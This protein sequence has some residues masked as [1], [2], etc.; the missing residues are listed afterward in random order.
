MEQKVLN[1][2]FKNIVTRE[3][4]GQRHDH[5]QSTGRL[6]ATPRQKNDTNP[7]GASSYSAIQAALTNSGGT[8]HRMPRL[9]FTCCIYV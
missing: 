3:Y 5:S 7:K 6:P 4:R 8:V 1:Q 2:S 9:I